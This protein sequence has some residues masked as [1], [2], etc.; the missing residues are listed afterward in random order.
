MLYQ[1]HTPVA[2][3][4]ASAVEA[5][6]LLDGYC[7]E[8]RLERIVPDATVNLIIDLDGRVRHVCDPVDGRP[9]QPCRGSWLSGLHTAPMTIEALPDTRLVA[10]R[11]RPGRASGLLG[12]RM[13]AFT[14][15]VVPGV[16]VFGAAIDGLRAELVGMKDARALLELAS[17]WFERRCEPAQ[18]AP[19]WLLTIVD[20][21]IATPNVSTLAGVLDACGHSQKHVI[22]LFRRHVG[23]PPKQLQRILRF[24]GVIAKV[25]ARE[26]ISWAELAVDCGYADQSHLI[27]DFGR[28][29]GYRPQRFRDA[30]HERVNFFPV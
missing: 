22:R 24:Q 16:E 11:L 25:L 19:P 15:R 28:F 5:M 20:S 18:A 1:P 6:F 29:S 23:V 13:D 3:P 30:G 10:L 26:E 21:L 27:R 17:R 4:L 9:T 7:P 2:G 12:P 8:H 14:D